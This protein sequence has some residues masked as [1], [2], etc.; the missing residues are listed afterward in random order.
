MESML[1]AAKNDLSKKE[2]VESKDDIQGQVKVMADEW[3]VEIPK[4]LR[5]ALKKLASQK[6]IN[7]VEQLIQATLEDLDSEV[8]EIEL[9]DA[10]N[11]D[12]VWKEGVEDLKDLTEK[13]LW[14]SLGMEASLPFFQKYTDPDA[15][16][17]PWSPEG[18]AWLADPK[19]SREPL[20][21]RWH[22]LVG[23]YRMLQRAFEDEPVLLMDGVGIG[24]TFQVIGFIACL[25]FFRSCY[26]THGRFPGAFGKS[27]TVFVSVTLFHP[28]WF[29]KRIKNGRERM[30]T[31]PIFPSL[32]YAL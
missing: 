28:C 8:P 18:V 25:A 27:F 20:Q 31:Y 10:E 29:R 24:K 22:Q 9:P 1:A 11:I 21:P 15:A 17:E 2:A 16:I 12:M 5:D 3:N 32:S 13:Q 30:A 6:A 4:A 23:I 7:E 19:S 14:N 26:E